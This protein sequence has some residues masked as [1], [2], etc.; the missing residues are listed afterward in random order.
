ME[1][2]QGWESVREQLI[3]AGIAELEMHGVADFSLRRVAAACNVSCAAPYKHFKGKEELI[4]A[5]FAY[6]QHQL[7]LLLAQVADVFAG[8]PKRQLVESGIAYIRFCMANPHFRGVLA[9]S[10][11]T[12]PL[13]DS[14]NTLL[15]LCCP[16]RD[17]LQEK[18]LALRSLI[19][20]ASV[21][22]ETGEL[23]NN[24]TVIDRIRHRLMQEITL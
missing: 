6:I 1:E 19:Y 9:L 22:L 20:G 17:D 21:L 23:P 14:V 8:D 10:G 18:A 5:I 15:P 16:E 13:A 4:D 24:K 7:D 3:V 11:Q 2:M 12:L